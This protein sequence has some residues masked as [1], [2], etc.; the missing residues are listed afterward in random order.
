MTSLPRIFKD[1]TSVICHESRPSISKVAILLS[2]AYVIRA[3]FKSYRSTYLSKNVFGPGGVLRGILAI[4]YT[5]II[6]CNRLITALT[7]HN[8]KDFEQEAQYLAN[9]VLAMYQQ[10]DLSELNESSFL[11]QEN[12]V[13]EATIATHKVWSREMQVY[14]RR[15]PGSSATIKRET[16]ERW[17]SLLG[18]KTEPLSRSLLNCPRAPTYRWDRF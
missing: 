3:R 11:A 13:A 17:C 12:C 16:F 10:S 7:R 5:C 15:G 2:R 14:I 18:R 6:L 8:S 4:L 9:E 1:V